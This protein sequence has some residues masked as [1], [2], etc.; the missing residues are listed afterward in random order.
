MSRAQTQR[1]R[2]PRWGMVLTAAIVVV[3]LVAGLLYWINQPTDPT[4]SSYRDIGGGVSVQQGAPDAI[5]AAVDDKIAKPPFQ[6]VQQLGSVVHVTPDGPQAKPVTLRFKLNRKIDDPKDVVIAVNQTG[7]AEDWQLVAPTKVEGQYAYVTTNHLSWWDPLWRSFADLVNATVEELKRLWNGL[8]GDAFAEAEKPKCDGE[9]AAR[10]KGYSIKWSGA[11]VLYWCLG[12]SGG[13]PVV[14]IANK[15]SYP[16][17]VNHAGI[18]APN[19]PKSKLGLEMLG[20]QAFSNDRTVMMPFDQLGLNYELSK[21]ESKSFTTEYNGFAEALYQLEFGITALFN[22]LTR[23]GAGGGAISNG[24]IKMSQ[25]DQIAEKMSKALQAKDCFNAV[26]TDNPNAGAI[27]SGCFD[28]SRIA[29]MFGWKGTLV[30][31]VMVAGPIANFFRNSFETLSDLLQ[32]K[33]QET[34]TVGYNPPEKPKVLFV[35][36][37]YVHGATMVIK[38]DATGAYTWNAGPCTVPTK[39]LDL[40]SGHAT[41]SFKTTSAAE[42]A[43]TYKRV[44]Y[45][46]GDD[47]EVTDKDVVDPE[48]QAGRTFTIKRNDTHSLIVSAGS[49]TSYLC[50]RYAR[51]HTNEGYS[52]CGA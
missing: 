3:A 2:K 30:A 35:G 43:G 45:T 37:W 47:T 16:I 28:P 19:K 32:G 38:A 11:E 51:T 33:D 31:L 42:M 48:V 27:L 17:F 26:N 50:D 40:C 49:A 22:I 21:A 13:K 10:D 34:V 29:D 20:R 5:R 1:R 15:R 46:A 14:N 18:S 39:E 52:I 24:A 6:Q 9:Q 8:T 7:K 25:F 4:A 12:L 41:I 36:E 44:W 23:F